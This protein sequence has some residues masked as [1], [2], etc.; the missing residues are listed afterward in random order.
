MSSVYV[1]FYKAEGNCV[2]KANRLFTR[3]KYSHCELVISR[4]DGYFNCYSSSP[5]DGGVRLKIMQLPPQSW[6][7]IPVHTLSKQRLKRFFNLTQGKKYD[8]LGAIGVVIHWIKQRQNRYFCSEW[9]A[10]LLEFKNPSK[11]SPQRLAVELDT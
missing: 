10:E 7:L 1:A 4:A 11:Y 8:F 2:D 9:V 6:D 5:R 3:G